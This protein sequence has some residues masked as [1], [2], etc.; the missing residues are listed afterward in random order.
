MRIGLVTPSWPG[1]ATAN[2][3]ATAVAHLEEGLREIGHDV[4]IIPH[5]HADEADPRVLNLPAPRDWTLLEKINR[6]LGRNTAA[7][8]IRAEQMTQAI[9]HAVQTR[10]IEALI[11]EESNGIAAMVQEN[12]A[13]PVVMTLHGPYVLHV[14]LHHDDPR[15]YTI[16]KRIQREAT[17]FHGCSGITSPSNDVLARMTSLYGTP[18]NPH[19]V[20]PNP[21]PTQHRMSAS[22]IRNKLHKLLFIGRFDLHKGGDVVIKAFEEVAAKDEE[23]TLTFVG[24]DSGVAMPDG[25]TQFIE[26][27]L[28]ALPLG[29][30]ARVQYQGQMTKPD[31]EALRYD[32][33]IAIVASRYETFAY[34]ALEAMSCGVPTVATSVGGLAENVHDM[35]T[36]LLVPSE[37]PTAMADACLRLINDPDLAV[38][39]GAQAHE[40]VTTQFSPAKVARDT[41]AFIKQ[42]L[43][44][45]GR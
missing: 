21:V 35:K 34:T 43:S 17:A 3:I 15:S 2:G 44:Q 32:H 16:R 40:A 20:I 36:G 1:G 29:V 13:I 12:I 6:R 8:P 42:I 45:G 37:D 27:A 23:A 9:Q 38:T 41:E 39:L 4:T 25:S 5:V 18:K 10:G 22:D 33:G 28:D 19:I 11:M 7:V 30:R 26:T 31:I 14:K 24:P